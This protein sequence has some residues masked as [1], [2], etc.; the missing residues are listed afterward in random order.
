MEDSSSTGGTT[1]S[2]SPEWTTTTTTVLPELTLDNGND[3]NEDTG[4]SENKNASGNEDRNEH[5][6]ATGAGGLK[7]AE[8]ADIIEKNKATTHPFAISTDA[9][10]VTLVPDVKSPE[11]ST[12][13]KVREGGEEQS[14]GFLTGRTNADETFFF[15]EVEPSAKQ[16]EV[17]R[18]GHLFENLRDHDG[19][20]FGSSSNLFFS[21]EKNDPD[22]G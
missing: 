13:A 3:E 17:L 18:G 11:N 6:A 15:F 20:I 22:C 4:G 19:L 12:L 16:S 10:D 8:K 9:G 21:G 1:I 14:S 2:P 7:A 5:G